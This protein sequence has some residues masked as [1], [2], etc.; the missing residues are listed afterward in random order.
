[1]MNSVGVF[2]ALWNYLKEKQAA[3]KNELSWLQAVLRKK[4]LTQ[5]K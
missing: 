4:K 3:F 5:T 1:M 2:S